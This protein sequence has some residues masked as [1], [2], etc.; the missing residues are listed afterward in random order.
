MDTTTN[1]PLPVSDSGHSTFE[2]AHVDETTF[3]EEVGND[4]RTGVFILVG[5]SVYGLVVMVVVLYCLSR[6]S[7]SSTCAPMA[8]CQGDCTCLKSIDCKID[9]PSCTDCCPECPDCNINICDDCTCCDTP[10]NDIACCEDLLPACQC[11]CEDI[12]EDAIVQNK[13]ANDPDYVLNLLRNNPNLQRSLREQQGISAFQNS[14]VNTTQ[15]LPNFSTQ[16]PLQSFN[17]SRGT[18]NSS[19]A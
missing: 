2:T 6:G 11:S 9:I 7:S 15:P 5:V 10:E 16:I 18:N 12:N 13:L 14:S 8:C 4:W 1:V 3:L 19:F 17:T